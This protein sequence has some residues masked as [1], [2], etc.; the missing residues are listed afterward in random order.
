MRRIERTK[1]FK[2]DYQRTIARPKHR[3]LD[4][5]LPA[6]IALLATDIAP[7][8][9]YVDHPLRGRWKD[10]RDCHVKPDLVL[11]YR[12]LSS[13]V[14]QLVRLGSHSELGF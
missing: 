14:L 12:K 10:F 7:P 8:E 4:N 11:I 5:V 3:D 9:K 6:L 2:K 1:A 13:D